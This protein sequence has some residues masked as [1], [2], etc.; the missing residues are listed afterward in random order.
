L[1]HP[2]LIPHLLGSLLRPRTRGDG[3]LPP[4]TVTGPVQCLHGRSNGRVLSKRHVSTFG[5]S[6]SSFLYVLLPK[7]GG[8]KHFHGWTRALS[9]APPLSAR[10]VRGVPGCTAEPPTAKPVPFPVW[11]ASVSFVECSITFGG[12]RRYGVWLVPGV[13]QGNNNTAGRQWKLW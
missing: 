5:C 7:T 3:H 9:P 1:S 4:S 13:W 10:G 2:L 8:Q 12:G 11:L 6:S